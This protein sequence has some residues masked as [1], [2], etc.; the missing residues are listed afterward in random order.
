AV[1]DGHRVFIIGEGLQL[2]GGPA[3]ASLSQGP[4]RQGPNLRVGT[5]EKR[6]NNW[7]NFAQKRRVPLR[8]PADAPEHGGPGKLFVKQT[9]KHGDNLVHQGYLMSADFPQGRGRPPAKTAGILVQQPQEAAD[10]LLHLAGIGPGQPPQGL[11]GSPVQQVPGV[12]EKL[13]QGLPN[14][15][16]SGRQGQQLRIIRF[17]EQLPQLFPEGPLIYQ[18]S[19]CPSLVSLIKK[20]G[21]AALKKSRARLPSW[22]V[23]AIPAIPKT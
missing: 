22:Q 7:Q 14:P 23:A 21:M 20:K 2:G 16:V 9:H 4:D 1:I 12:I 13:Q 15:P 17:P 3:I 6:L 19:L 5:C 18:G 10:E 8:Q 11:Q